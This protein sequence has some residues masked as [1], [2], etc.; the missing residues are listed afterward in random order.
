MLR[1]F[2]RVVAG[3]VLTGLAILGLRVLRAGR[4]R[5][6]NPSREDERF[7]LHADN[8][9]D[10]VYRFRFHPTPGFEYISPSSTAVT[11]YSPEEHY[12]DPDLG[13]K[14]ATRK[15]DTCWR[16]RCALRKSR[17]CCAGIARTAA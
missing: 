4:L 12:A 1:Q 6:L 9:R 15:T 17:S 3:G 8:A 16:A 5:S 2:R 11:G 14:R 10:L 7:R 13:L